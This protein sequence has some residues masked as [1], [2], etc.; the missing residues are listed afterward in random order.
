MMYVI[1]TG[2]KF[3]HFADLLRRL[4]HTDLYEIHAGVKSESLPANLKKYVDLL[5]RLV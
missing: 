2:E 4:E 5:P 1:T 3:V